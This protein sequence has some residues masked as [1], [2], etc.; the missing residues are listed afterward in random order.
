MMESNDATMKIL[1]KARETA[2]DV[3]KSL[4]KKENITAAE[5]EG[6]EKAVCLIKSIKIVEAMTN[7]QFDDSGAS[8]MRRP[9][10]E[11]YSTRRY[12]DG[13]IYRNDGYS[14]HSKRDRMIA[15]LEEMYDNAQSDHERQ[16]VQEWLDRINYRN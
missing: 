4:T 13:H 11:G 9:A 10:T 15:A 3:I 14:G 5:L 7:G 1:D 6:I 12:Y 2:E 16:F 8:H